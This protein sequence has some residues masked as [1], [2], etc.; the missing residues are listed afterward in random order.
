[1]RLLSVCLPSGETGCL[2]LLSVIPYLSLSCQPPVDKCQSVGVITLCDR[3]L[4][5]GD[6]V[7]MTSTGCLF[8]ILSLLCWIPCHGRDIALLVGKDEDSGSP[9]MELYS[10]DG[11]LLSQ[12]PELPNN[13]T[14]MI[15]S[16]IYLDYEDWGDV[17]LCS[18][19]Y[20]KTDCYF[21]NNWNHPPL[22]WSPFP[23]F[24]S[25]QHLSFLH[26]DS[27]GSFWALG[28]WTNAQSKTWFYKSHVGWS[29]GPDLPHLTRHQCSV[30]FT[31]DN[32]SVYLLIGGE[33]EQPPRDAGI[34]VLCKRQ[35]DIFCRY[36]TGQEWTIQEYVELVFQN[37]QTIIHMCQ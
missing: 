3:I 7:T 18:L 29:E 37:C 2:L 5:H 30:K 27:P 15:P 20:M 12:L 22:S 34:Q 36:G 10:E 16:A 24:D 23:E 13:F 21:L 4:T 17:V 25:N 8:L 9:N 28:S 11:V 6:P 32:E 1:M 26:A 14:T 35:N 33:E 31:V 19:Y